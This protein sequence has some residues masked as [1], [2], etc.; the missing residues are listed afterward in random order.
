[1]IDTVKT[2]F[3]KVQ[4]LFHY[5]NPSEQNIQFITIF[6]NFSYYYTNLQKYNLILQTHIA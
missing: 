3:F 1:M 5:T 4:K 2:L 6:V